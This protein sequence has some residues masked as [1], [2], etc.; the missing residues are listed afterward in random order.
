MLFDLLLDTVVEHISLLVED[1]VVGISI[2]LLVAKLGDVVILN[3]GDGV[4]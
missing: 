3:L 4:D 2:V 1:E